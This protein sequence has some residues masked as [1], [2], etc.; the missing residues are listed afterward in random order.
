MRGFVRGSKVAAIFLIAV[1]VNLGWAGSPARADDRGWTRLFGTLAEDTAQ[2]VSI[3][4]RDVYAYGRTGG[5]LPGQTSAGGQ[6]V[7]LRK[8][9]REG[10]HV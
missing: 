4:G 7:Y 9:D 5:V 8:F 10:N 3:D 1:T 2:G 6:D